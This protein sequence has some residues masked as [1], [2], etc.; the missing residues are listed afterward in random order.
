MKYPL[1]SRRAVENKIGKGGNGFVFVINHEQKQYA[2]KKVN[3]NI[4]HRELFKVI[5]QCIYIRRYTDP[6]KLMFIQ[7]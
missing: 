2:V 1:P 6:M 7:H 5:K 4:T 3:G